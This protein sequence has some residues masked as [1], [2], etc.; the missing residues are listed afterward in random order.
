M[1]IEQSVGL[2]VLVD[3]P[4]L[5]LVA[6]LQ[7]RGKRD[8]EAGGKPESWSGGCQ[9]T[10]HGKLEVEDENNSLA[11]LVREA[12]EE[13]GPVAAKMIFDQAI[14]HGRLV[15]VYQ[16]QEREKY[17][18]TYALQMDPSFIGRIRFSPSAGGL[19]L[20]LKK[21]VD[22]ILDLRSFIKEDGVRDSTVIAMFPDEKEALIMAFAVFAP[23]SPPL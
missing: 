8:Y 17:V 20:I 13:L 18:V 23:L 19:E 14:V 6:L 1:N 7:R 5:G 3:M 9:V 10:V 11:A 15:Q 4:G 22:G 12:K 16:L 21:Q 2:V